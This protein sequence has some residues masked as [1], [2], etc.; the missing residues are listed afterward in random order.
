MRELDLQRQA[1]TL[2]EQFSTENS[3][4]LLII[5]SGFRVKTPPLH[6]LMEDSTKGTRNSNSRTFQAIRRGGT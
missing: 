4:L 5:F 2:I 6:Y 3:N 1:V